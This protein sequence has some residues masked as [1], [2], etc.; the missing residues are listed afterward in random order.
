MNGYGSFPFD[1]IMSNEVHG[2]VSFP[3]YFSGC[4]G[5]CERSLTLPYVKTT[6]YSRFNSWVKAILLKVD[7][8]EVILYY[9]DVSRIY[10]RFFGQRYRPIWYR[11]LPRNLIFMWLIILPFL[12]KKSFYYNVSRE[13]KAV[14][15]CVRTLAS[16]VWGSWV[17]T[18][19]QNIYG[20]DRIVLF[21][22]STE[23]RAWPH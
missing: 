14:L 5:K 23:V 3:L 20:Q 12:I 4:L 1:H 7:R 17:R 18:S 11:N 2:R 22:P 21:R 8:C 6:E 16:R 9:C 10:L 13:E 15:S 19:I